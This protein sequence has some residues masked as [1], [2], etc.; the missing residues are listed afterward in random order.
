M[1]PRLLLL[2]T[3]G[4]LL[5]VTP[6]ANAHNSRGWYW[7]DYLAEGR[8]LARYSD[9]YEVECT[10]WGHSIRARDSRRARL[11]RHFDCLL[12]YEDGYIEE[13]ELHVTRRR[14]FV[15]RD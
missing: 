15:M 12:T 10:G 6:A 14:G 13:D 8:V 9:V 5:A 11:Y 3:V 7:S 1:Q 2:V 4:L